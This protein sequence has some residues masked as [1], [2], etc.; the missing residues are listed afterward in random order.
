MSQKLEIYAPARICLFGE[1]Q[2]Y[3]GL[4]VIASSINL[5]LKITGEKRSDNLLNVSLSDINEN[6]TIAPQKTLEYRTERDYLQS[7]I[8]VLKRDNLEF[9]SGY[10][11][12][13]TSN[14]PINAGVSS[15]SALVV[16]WLKFL[17]ESQNS[18]NHSPNQLAE[19]AYQTE[20]AEFNE[21]GGKMDHYTI[22]LG[23]LIY[24]DT[25][26]PIK[27]DKL[28]AF[29][30][31]N[32][33]EDFVLGN[34]LEKK[35]TVDLLKRTKRDVVNGLTYLENKTSFNRYSTPLEEINLGILPENIQTKV[36]ANII[37]RDI[38][39]KARKILS[40]AKLSDNDKETIGNLINQHQQQLR[41][42]GLSTRK[43][44]DLIEASLSAGALGAK[45]TGSGGG[46]CMFAYCPNYQ[47]EVKESIE[48]AG[49]QAYII[50]PDFGVRVY[51]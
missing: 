11:I 8:N 22:S 15:S 25:R 31:L 29:Q 44:D 10:D 20:V 2:D 13:I 46:G 48:K 43:L 18:K 37:N 34:S 36:K 12:E 14:I 6:Y 39:Q 38:T 24:I 4:P 33:L 23:G 19:L 28:N 42:L 9:N 40:K 7:A 47:E 32:N 51:K 26:N 30:I 17:L 35:D 21:A 27:V 41:I 45:F 49:G 1:H 5:K 16:A 50:K 3:L